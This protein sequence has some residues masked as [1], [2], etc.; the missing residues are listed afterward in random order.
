MMIHWSHIRASGILL[1]LATL[2]LSGC[3]VG[4]S[5]SLPHTSR[6]GTATIAVSDDGASN[7]TIIIPN[8]DV[9]A[10]YITVLT[11]G[12]TV[13]WLNE[14]T[15]L[16]T[17]LTAPTAQGGAVN[18]AQFQIVLGPGEAASRTLRQ[19]GVYYYYCDAHATLRDG[20]PAAARPGM[21]AYPVPMDGFLYVR[22]PGSAGSP[23][24]PSSCPPTAVSR[25]GSR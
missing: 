19:P 25:H 2:L 10:P 21:R 22:V 4:G 3:A 1:A 6:S 9:F 11:A 20:G 23:S 8:N 24:R 5:G 14:D 7:S 15:V 18:P 13:T 16:H 12:D 17:I